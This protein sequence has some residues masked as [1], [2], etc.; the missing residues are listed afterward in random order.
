MTYNPDTEDNLETEL[1]QTFADLGY[2]TVNAFK[3]VFGKDGTLGRDNRQETV[4]V[5]YLREA[6]EYFN[7]DLPNVAYIN[8]IEQLTENRSIKGSLEL[9]NQEIYDLL[10]DRITVTYHDPDE[11]EDAG[12]TLQII[13]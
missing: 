3:E 13:D 11:G 4:L 8:A 12:D 2:E 1:M 5:R 7:P 6:L 9:A 10:K